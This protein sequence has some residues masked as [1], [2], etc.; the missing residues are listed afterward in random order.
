MIKK[1]CN[2]VIWLTGGSSGI[3]R[4]LA[5]KLAILN[6]IVYISAR[7]SSM[8]ASL[9]NLYPQNIIGMQ[10]DI[11]EKNKVEAH[12]QRIRQDHQHIDCLILNAGTAEYVD[13]NSF[14][15]ALFQRVFAINFFANVQALE[16]AL[17]LLRQGHGKYIVGIS[18]SVVFAPFPRAE[19]YGASKAA[20]S[21]LLDSLRVDLSHEGFE[22]SIVYPGFVKTPLTD[23][24]DFPMP[25]RINANIAAE[26]IISGLHHR[27]QQIIFPWGFCFILKMCGLLPSK[28]RNIVMQKIRK[29]DTK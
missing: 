19:A 25:M 20:F 4:E 1:L 16:C 27:C 13:S 7:D 22:I 11:T 15:N 21:Y 26:H 14:N 12:V 17:P 23:K 2:Q 29:G 28:L 5:I 6:N 10:G 18:S 8:L 9:V 3:G 24:N